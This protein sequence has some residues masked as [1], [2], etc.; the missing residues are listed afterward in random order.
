M[1]ILKLLSVRNKKNKEV[2]KNYNNKNIAASTNND[3][4][5]IN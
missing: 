2:E 1:I 4:I 5:N 3:Y